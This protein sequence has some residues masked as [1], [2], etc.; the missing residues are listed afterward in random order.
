MD[1]DSVAV[2]AG[3]ALAAELVN[4]FDGVD[5]DV[6]RTRDQAALAGK[7]VLAGLERLVVV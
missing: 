5:G 3:D 6:A 1:D 7:G 4:L 2:G